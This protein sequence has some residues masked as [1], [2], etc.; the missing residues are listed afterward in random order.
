[1]IWNAFFV[2]MLVG[3]N[4][5]FVAAEFALV[6][7][8]ATEIE[9][10]ENS[11]KKSKVLA[12][13]VL[14][15]L[16]SYLSACQFGI[17]IA[18]LGLGWIGESVVAR[19][20]EPIFRSLGLPEEQL[21]Y[22][23]FP[24]AFGV[25]TFLLLT[26][27]EQAPKIGAIRRARSTTFLV[28]YPLIIFNK[29]FWP[30]IWLIN[31]SSN[32]I[33]KVFGIEAVS[34]YG[35]KITEEEVRMI[36][37][38]SAATGQLGV[39]EQQ[40]IEGVLDLRDKNA[41]RYMIPRNQ[42]VY[43][44]RQDSMSAKLKIAASCGHTRLPLCEVD[45][46]HVVGVLHIKDIFNSVTL[47]DE[48]TSLSAVARAPLFLPEA[49]RL[50][51]LLKEF[52]RSKNHL[53]ILV[54]EYGSVSGMITLENVI[55]EMV[56]PIED[57]FDAEV[58]LILK[59]GQ[60]RFEVNARCPVDEFVLKCGVKVRTGTEVDSVGGVLIEILGHIPQAGEKVQLVDHIVTI[61]KSEPTRVLWVL[62]EKSSTI[63]EAKSDRI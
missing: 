55:E 47:E 31:V 49:I 63:V 5:F 1:M 24:V 42:I 38:Q 41:R 8:R 7:V 46:D 16:D 21:R 59:K 9:P 29:V 44:N 57:E 52:Q 33:L 58:P 61:I 54:D 40:I 13:H 37:T 45:M 19:M 36:L 60:D 4:G 43:L 17:T 2:L 28:L 39:K 50:D 48:L 20:L 25:I 51:K 22:F 23:S 11:T 35:Q 10:D 18:S 6:K 32:L 62:V 30:F 26:L 34:K 27:G 14:E 15:H 12:H 3:I 56:G 53:A